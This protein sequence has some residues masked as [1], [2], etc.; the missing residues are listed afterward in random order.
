MAVAERG[1]HVHGA[2]VAAERLPR[3]E[4]RAEQ[5]Q[6]EVELFRPGPVARAHG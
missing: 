3:A 4:D 1:R 6:T 2:R 5:Y